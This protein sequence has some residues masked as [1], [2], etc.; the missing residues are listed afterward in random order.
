MW[1][2]AK[3]KWTHNG[4]GSKGHEAP[5]FLGTLIFRGD[6]REHNPKKGKGKPKG[7]AQKKNACQNPGP[8]P[9]ASNEKKIPGEDKGVI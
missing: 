4:E 7:G 2:G 6:F 8:P 5:T 9:K 1:E 3:K